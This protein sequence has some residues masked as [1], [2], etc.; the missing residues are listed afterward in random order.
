VLQ[1]QAPTEDPGSAYDPVP[2][3]IA[4]TSEVI[5]LLDIREL[6]VGP[7]RRSFP[8]QTRRDQNERE[9]EESKPHLL[10]GSSMALPTLDG[11]V[12]TGVEIEGSARPL[13][14]KNVALSG[15]DR[16][17]C[18]RIPMIHPPPFI[19]LQ[20]A[21]SVLVFDLENHKDQAM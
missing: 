10:I 20:N 3:T 6:P 14:D 9:R 1:L 2:V 4:F 8:L 7:L 17:D 19:C 5:T 15:F 21:V 13:V 18:L 12:V 11:P 16:H